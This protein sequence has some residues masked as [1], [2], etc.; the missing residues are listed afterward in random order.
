LIGIVI[1][2]IVVVVKSMRWLPPAGWP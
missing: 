1:A 2:I